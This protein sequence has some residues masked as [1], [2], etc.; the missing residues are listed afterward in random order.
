MLQFHHATTAK[1]I[2]ICTQDPLINS[3]KIITVTYS[4]EKTGYQLLG[5]RYLS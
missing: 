5:A 3:I 1:V 2:I 4:T